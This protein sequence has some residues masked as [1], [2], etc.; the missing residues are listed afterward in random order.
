MAIQQYP[1]ASCPCYL[2]HAG[3]ERVADPVAFAEYM[4]HPDFPRASAYDPM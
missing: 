4:T 2:R 1:S 3:E